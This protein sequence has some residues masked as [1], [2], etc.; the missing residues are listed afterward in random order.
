MM[1]LRGKTSSPSPVRDGIAFR[2][3][4]LTKRYNR[5]IAGYHHRFDIAV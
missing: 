1:I 5:T 3:F 2:T 4:Q